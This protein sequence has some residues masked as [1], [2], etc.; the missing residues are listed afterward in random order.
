MSQERATTP[1]KRKRSRK[2]TAARAREM[3]SY[4]KLTG[5]VRWRVKRGRMRAGERAGTIS[6]PHPGS[7]YRRRQIM[8]DRRCYHEHQVIWLIVTGEWCRPEVDHRDTDACNNRWSNLRRATRLQQ[9]HNST[10]SERNRAGLKW[11]RTIIRDDLIRPR[12]QATVFGK[13]LGTFDTP[14]RAH[15]VAVLYAKKH[16]GAFFNSGQ[17]QAA[18]KG[19]RM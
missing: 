17:R 15:R 12:Y 19:V 10:V 9:M 11:V 14:E 7:P 6:A 13:Y 16:C 4:D 5:I 3:F 8:I 1:K 2:L 18:S